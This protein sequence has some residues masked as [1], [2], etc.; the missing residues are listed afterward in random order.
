MHIVSLGNLGAQA[1]ICWSGKAD[2]RC[3]IHSDRLLGIIVGISY[4]NKCFITIIT[5]PAVLEF[6][7]RISFIFRR[8]VRIKRRF[9]I[10]TLNIFLLAIF[11]VGNMIIIYIKRGRVGRR[12]NW[13]DR[14][15]RSYYNILAYLSDF[16]WIFWLIGSEECGRGDLTQKTISSRKF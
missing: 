3:I 11:K 9:V 14:L 13:T 2:C 8:I 6:F 15:K 16:T 10:V 5:F 7:L 12:R 1:T 4:L